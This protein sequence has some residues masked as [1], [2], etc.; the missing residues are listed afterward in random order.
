MWSLMLGVRGWGGGLGGEVRKRSWTWERRRWRGEA[1]EANIERGGGG[2]DG[3][4]ESCASPRGSE[5][6]EAGLEGEAE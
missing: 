2:G 6:V 5:E 4:E 1:R 3:E